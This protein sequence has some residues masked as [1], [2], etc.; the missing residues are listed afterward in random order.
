MTKCRTIK[1]GGEVHCTKISPTFEDQGQGHQGTAESFQMTMHS[2]A[3]AVARSH[4]AHSNI[5]CHPG[6]VGYA[7]GKIS[8]CCLV[9][10]I[11][12][13]SHTGTSSLLNKE[14]SSSGMCEIISCNP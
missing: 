4:A 13:F 9:Y 14:A 5:A 7:S 3:C 12:I 1:F 2:R 11:F 10:Q 8:A 6:V